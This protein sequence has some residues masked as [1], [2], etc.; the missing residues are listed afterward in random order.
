MSVLS[1]MNTEHGIMPKAPQKDSSKIDNK[2]SAATPKD[3]PSVKAGTKGVTVG[4]M[5]E[6]TD[7]E[8]PTR[9]DFGKVKTDGRKMDKGAKI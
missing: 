7:G 4:A 2:G 6:Y 9:K 8:P 1:K 3:T 5:K